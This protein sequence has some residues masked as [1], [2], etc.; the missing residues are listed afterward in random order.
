MPLAAA[1]FQ[2]DGVVQFGT[3]QP[4]GLTLRLGRNEAGVKTS[5]AVWREMIRKRYC[6][7]LQSKSDIGL[8]GIVSLHERPDPSSSDIVE[9]DRWDA[10]DQ[11]HQEK[12]WWDF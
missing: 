7:P 10:D 8:C 3:N 11:K 6:L 12:D 1:K 5:V 4:S 2:N 9:C